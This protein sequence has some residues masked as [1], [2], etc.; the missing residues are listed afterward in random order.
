MGERLAR[1]VPTGDTTENKALGIRFVA[2]P[3]SL[4]DVMVDMVCVIRP[5]GEDSVT[6][7]AGTDEATICDVVVVHNDQE[8]GGPKW[9]S[10]SAQPLF[11]KVIRQQLR[12]LS[13]DEFPWLAGRITQCGVGRGKSWYELRPLTPAETLRCGEAMVAYNSAR[14]GRP[15][16]AAQ[17]L[18]EHG[19]P[20]QRRQAEQ[21]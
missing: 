8:G 20:A 13:C 2:P 4:K 7:T 18:A 3:L 14:A 21:S 1:D 16:T 12:D 5:I 9:R 6:T 10:Y 15:P 17:A 19:T 11:W